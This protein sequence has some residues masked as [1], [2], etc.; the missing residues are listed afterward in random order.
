MSFASGAPP[1]F[2]RD[3]DLQAEISDTDAHALAAQVICEFIQVQLGDNS[4]AA[5]QLSAFVNSTRTLVQ[6][7]WDSMVCAE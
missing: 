3:F 4:T 6:P 1:S 7:L 2:V 5:E